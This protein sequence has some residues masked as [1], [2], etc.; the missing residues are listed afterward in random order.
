MVQFLEVEFPLALSTATSLHPVRLFQSEMFVSAFVSLAE[1]LN[2]TEVELRLAL[3]FGELR[4]SE[5]G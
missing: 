5:G 1:Q 3:L 4:V 2:D